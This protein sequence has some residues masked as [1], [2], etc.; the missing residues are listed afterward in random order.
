[1]ANNELLEIFNR[2]LILHVEI[3]ASIQRV[4]LQKKNR[5]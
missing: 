3:L 1:M 2:K 4:N 5:F